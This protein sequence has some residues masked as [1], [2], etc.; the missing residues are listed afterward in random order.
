MMILGKMYV[1]LTGLCVGSF[2]NVCIYRLPKQISIVKPPSFCPKCNKP[3]KW[4]D[5]IPIFSFLVLGA[6]CR[7]CKE[8]I[9]FRYFFDEVSP[10]Q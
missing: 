5:N 7:D 4:H 9:S 3:I 2:L 1:F 8:K 10:C 6:R